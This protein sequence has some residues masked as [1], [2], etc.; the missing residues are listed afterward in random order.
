MFIEDVLKCIQVFTS[1][2]QIFHFEMAQPLVWEDQWQSNFGR[3][4][5]KNHCHHVCD[6]SLG[7]SSS[8]K[9]EWWTGGQFN[10]W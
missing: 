1:Q 7:I 5:E 9:W 2:L 10:N 6:K 4:W 3:R 8:V